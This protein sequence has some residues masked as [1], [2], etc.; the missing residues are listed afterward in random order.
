MSEWEEWIACADEMP[1]PYVVVLAFCDDTM[2]TAF[3]SRHTNGF[4]SISGEQEIGL[5]E[6]VTHWIHLPY[7]PSSDS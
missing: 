4:V 3:F 1:M 6:D 5:L 2:Y 7:H